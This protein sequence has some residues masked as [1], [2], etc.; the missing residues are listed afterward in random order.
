[1][2]SS[3]FVYAQEENN[4]LDKKE[5]GNNNNDNNTGANTNNININNKTK[6]IEKLAGTASEYY[7]SGEYNEAIRYSD[8]MLAVDGNNMFALVN[9]GAA[10]YNLGKTEEAIAYYDRALAIDANYTMH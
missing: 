1:M 7:L 4:I 3:L 8:R 9:K 6:G 2:T 10:L 5:I